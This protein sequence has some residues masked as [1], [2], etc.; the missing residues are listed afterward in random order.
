V[1]PPLPPTGEKIVRFV[2]AAVALYEAARAF[3]DEERRAP[4]GP[5]RR[6]AAPAP[7]RMSVCTGRSCSRRADTAGLMADLRQAAGGQAVTVTA[8]PCLKR[9]DEGPVVV[10][11]PGAARERVFANVQRWNV[12]DIVQAISTR[13]Q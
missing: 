1:R 9:C 13:R 11:A 7:V 5:Q 10:A 4:A 8:T 3:Y 2:L 6:P 12:P